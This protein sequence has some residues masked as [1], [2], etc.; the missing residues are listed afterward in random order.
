MCSLCRLPVAKNHKIGQILTLGGFCTD[1]LLPMRDKFGAL[2]SIPTMHV[3]VSKSPRS[4]YSIALWRRKPLIFAIFWT[5][6]FIDVD[7]WRQSQKLEHGCTTTI[8]KPSP[9]QRH[10]NR[11]CTSQRLHGEIWRT[12]SDVQITRAHH[13]IG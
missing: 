2:Y 10:Q 6:A 13:K 12:N 1:H 5:S 4:V 9:I 7:S 8:Y 11:F 3:Y